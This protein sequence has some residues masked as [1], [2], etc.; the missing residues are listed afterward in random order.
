MSTPL[1]WLASAQ[2]ELL[3]LEQ[4]HAEHE[5]DPE[6]AYRFL[7]LCAR[8][9]QARATGLTVELPP[10][11]EELAAR[12]APVAARP[13]SRQLLFQLE[14]LLAGDDDP[15]GELLGVLLAVDDA[16]TVDDAEGRVDA[17][18]ELVRMADA[19]V[20]LAPERVGALGE[21]AENR[22]AALPG[23]ASIRVLW[24]T[25]AE[26]AGQAVVEALPPAV[27]APD[28]LSRQRL[29]KKL[30]TRNDRIEE[31]V[32]AAPPLLL[33]RKVAASSARDSSEELF[34]GRSVD[35]YFEGEVLHLLVALPPGRKAAG[36][37]EL[38]LG[39]RERTATWSL[40]IQSASEQAVIA[41]LGTI[42]ELRERLRREGL[43]DE[44]RLVV[45]LSM[46]EVSE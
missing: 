22:L 30:R 3:E 35:I 20:S 44:P 38:H 31:D 1:P 13:E 7:V 42:E 2:E 27:P 18:H 45:V 24:D 36:N 8:L 11:L 26:A 34:A 16:A 14:E 15:F 39:T 37:V 41:R 12:C 25:I 10:R 28:S 33:L 40:P 46:K 5:L 4:E 17:A 21:L 23:D 9:D 43:M 32:S 6:S 29:L 19:Y